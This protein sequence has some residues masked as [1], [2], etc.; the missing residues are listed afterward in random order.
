ML[1]D[2]NCGDLRASDAGTT[3]TLAGRVNRRRDHGGLIF[4]DLRDHSGLVQIV[5]NPQEAGDAHKVGEELRGEY[6]LQVTVTDS[7]AK[8]KDRAAE[9]WIDF[10]VMK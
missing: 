4:I 1:K 8:L 7:L 5:F 2:R 3:V 6:V 10:Q 9:S